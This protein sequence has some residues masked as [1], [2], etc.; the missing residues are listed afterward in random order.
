MFTMIV[1]FSEE[2]VAEPTP[3]PF[4]ADIDY[5]KARCS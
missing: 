1:S 5:D 4:L 3:T 2:G